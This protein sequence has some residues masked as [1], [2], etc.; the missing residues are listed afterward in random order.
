MSNEPKVPEE[1]KFA[2]IIA[3]VYIFIAGYS[4]GEFS[5]SEVSV[6]KE[7][8]GEWMGDD[9]TRTDINKL[10]SEAG[11]WYDSLDEE[12]LKNTIVNVTPMLKEQ[13]NDD[14]LK[15]I[16]I[17]LIAIAEAD[18]TVTKTEAT[19]V[20]VITELLGFTL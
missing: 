4:D 9:A 16:I 17:D 13:F 15:A 7:K 18:G 11:E 6:I 10:V 2:H 20:Q 3:L 1:I 12:G 14:A 5:Q 19:N 8:I